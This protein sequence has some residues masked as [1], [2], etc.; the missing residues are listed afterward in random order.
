MTPFLEKLRE[1]VEDCPA[2]V[3]GWSLDGKEFKVKSTEQFEKF[4]KRYFKGTLK[5]YVDISGLF[6]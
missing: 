6:Q 4:L 1:I 3:G 5:T 2:E